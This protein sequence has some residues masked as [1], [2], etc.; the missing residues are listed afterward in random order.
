MN[1]KDIWKNYGRI[2]TIVICY[3]LVFSLISEGY[4]ISDYIPMLTAL[5]CAY[6]GWGAL[7]KIQPAMFVWMPLAG[8]AIYFFVKFLLSYVIGIFVAP[9]KIGTEIANKI[10]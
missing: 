7:N 9:Y 3:I 8:W 5:I 2:I 1:K 10:G 6:F 4:A